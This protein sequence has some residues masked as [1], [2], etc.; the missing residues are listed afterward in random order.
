[1][2]FSESMNQCLRFELPAL[3]SILVLLAMAFSNSSTLGTETSAQTLLAET[4][5]SNLTK[6]IPDHSMNNLLIGSADPFFWFLVPIFGVIC[7]GL[8]IAINYAILIVTH[9]LM[10]PA[11][12]IKLLSRMDDTRYD[13]IAIEVFNA[14][15]FIG[16][17]LRL[18]SQSLR[19]N[20]ELLLRVFCLDS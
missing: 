14:N 17:P 13:R 12:Y 19:P 16:G 10:I 7:T 5:R 4:Y 1:M 2:S 11:S 8:C 6:S 18:R 20:S 3:I 9:I 15:S